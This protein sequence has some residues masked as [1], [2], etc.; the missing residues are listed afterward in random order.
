MALYQ[1]HKDQPQVR[2][3]N[4]E[5]VFQESKDAHDHLNLLGEE[6]FTWPGSEWHTRK[7]DAEKDITS[8]KKLFQKLIDWKASLEIYSDKDKE[9]ANRTASKDRA[10]KLRIQQ[11]LTSGR[12]PSPLAEKVAYELEGL[13]GEKNRFTQSLKGLRW[14]TRWSMFLIKI[15]ARCSAC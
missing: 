4:A 1:T 11:D 13:H 6:M 15:S 5:D 7:A 14:P 8:F 12:T 9:A 10:L 3:L 2:Q